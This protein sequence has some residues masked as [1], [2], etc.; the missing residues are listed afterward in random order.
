MSVDE[1]GN[2]VLVQGE[3]KIHVS[4]AS[5]MNRSMELGVETLSM[6]IVVE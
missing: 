6:G 3:Y 2:R 5:P 4:G 1:A